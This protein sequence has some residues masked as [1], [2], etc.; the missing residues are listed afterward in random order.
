MS[1]L[2]CMFDFKINA[3]KHGLLRS[4]PPRQPGAPGVKK[5]TVK[6]IILKKLAKKKMQKSIFLDFLKLSKKYL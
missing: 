4:I 6:K 5:Y 3:K 2:F 1:Y